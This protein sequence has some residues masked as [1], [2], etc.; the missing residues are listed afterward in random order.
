MWDFRAQ[1]IKQL[2]QQCK[3]ELTFSQALCVAAQ[4]SDTFRSEA[5]LTGARC[6]APL[7]G[8]RR[9]CEEIGI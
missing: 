3:H 1:E 9:A 8:T 5:L 4:F 7:W 6:V 2:G